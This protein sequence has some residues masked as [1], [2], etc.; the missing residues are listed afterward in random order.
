MTTPFYRSLS[1]GAPLEV[2]RELPFVLSQP[3]DHGAPLRL[4]GQIDLLCVD[5]AA[6]VVTIV[7]YKHSRAGAGA[8][9]RFQLDAYALA[10]RRILPDMPRVRAGLAFLREGDPSPTLVDH[11]AARCDDFAADLGRLG[12]ALWSSRATD[13][14]QGQPE[15]VCRDLGC[16]FLRRCH[17]GSI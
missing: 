3:A 13:Q 14:F 5:R 12:A 1:A 17:R 9:Y 7:D 11:D 6:G 8:D 10:A 16:G 15:P 4:R 2:H